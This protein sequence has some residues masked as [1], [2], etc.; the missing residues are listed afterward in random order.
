MVP[1]SGVITQVS[2]GPYTIRG[3]SV[4]G[5]YTSLHVPEL[6]VLF[7]VGIPLRS[8]AGV[9]TL[10]LSHAHADHAGALAGLLGIRALHGIK[11]PLRVVMPAEIVR[12]MLEALRAMAELQ[13]WP[14][15]IEAVGVE[16]GDVVPLRRDLEVR[17]FRTFHPVPSLGYQLF[18]R[19]H[20]LR[21]EFQGLPGPELASLRKAG[22]P[23]T[24]EAEHRELAYATDTLVQV[25]DHEPSILDSRVLAIECTFLDARKSIEHARAGCHVHLDELVERADRIANPHVVLMHFSQ[26][27]RPDEIRP[28]LAQRLPPA[29]HAR[30][31]PFA[32]VDGDW[33]G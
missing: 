11:T 14:L 2:A 19:T 16:P 27:Y 32:P 13:R 30:V 12:T 29:L 3:V 15:D 26:L 5:V 23:I 7:D 1:P 10:L 8:A 6:D 21:P 4:G 18:R 33:F 17:A 22:T 20:K 25:I 24:D 28:I 31:V 9:G